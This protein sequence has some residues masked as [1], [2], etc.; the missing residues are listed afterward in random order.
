[1]LAAALEAGDP[2][3]VASALVAAAS[4]LG[5]PVAGQTAAAAAVAT[6]VERRP[7]SG[8]VGAVDGVRVLVG[9]ERLL[10]EE[11]V[12]LPGAFATAAREA[13]ESGELVVWIAADGRVLGGVR[14][15]DR[16][17]PE[18]AVAIA[19]LHARGVSTAMVSGDALATCEAVASEL[20]IDRVLAD[21]LPHEKERAVRELA[22][23]GPLAFVGDGI[24]DA[25]AL[26]A[27]DLAV[28][29][30]GGSDVAVLA[31]DV[32]LTGEGSPL[33]SLPALLDIATVT[34]RIIAENLVWAFSYNLVAIPLAVTGTLSPIAAAAAM[35]GSSLA[36]VANSLRI[37]RAG[38]KR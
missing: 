22:K 29:V 5:Q 30:G 19:A 37:L 20:G 32:V 34:R 7:G 15:A 4:E 1:V 11:R 24:N 23:D 21:V 33:A 9:S 13:R 28:A 25:A 12:D 14:F 31:A 36:V 6:S 18:A 27:S 38:G 10:A 26:S 16:L 8:L 35:A 17:R 2:H 3:P